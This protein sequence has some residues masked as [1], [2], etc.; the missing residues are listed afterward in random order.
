MHSFLSPCQTAKKARPR[1]ADRDRAV[2][3]RKLGD[4]GWSCRQLAARYNC[5]PSTINNIML[6]RGAYSYLGSREPKP[7]PAPINEIEREIIDELAA[8]DYTPKQIG[9][10]LQRHPQ[11]II[12]VLKNDD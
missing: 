10:I 7:L 9:V 6:G 8:R 2:E 12:E 11:T 5:H 1:S 3:I 4:N